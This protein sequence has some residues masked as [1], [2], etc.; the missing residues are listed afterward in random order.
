[1]ISERDLL[2]ELQFSI[3]SRSIRGACLK[4]NVAIFCPFHAECCHVMLT[5]H[6]YQINFIKLAS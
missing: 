3:N 2:E 5:C 4:E 6:L 1:M